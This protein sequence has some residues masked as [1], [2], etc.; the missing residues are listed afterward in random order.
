MTPDAL[1]SVHPAIIEQ[2]LP[3]FCRL[4]R[5]LVADPPTQTLRIRAIRPLDISRKTDLRTIRWLSNHPLELAGVRGLVIENERPNS[6]ALVDQPSTQESCDHP[7]TRYVA[8][9]LERVRR[10]LVTTALSLKRPAGHG[11]RDPSAT[12]AAQVLSSAGLYWMPSIVQ[13]DSPFTMRWR[14]FTGIGTLCE[15]QAVLPMRC[16]LSFLASKK[17]QRFTVS[18]LIWRLTSSAQY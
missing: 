18:R 3:I 8:Y 10:R 2:Q 13:V 12:I 15:C 16:L 9:L 11:V 14:T 4:L 1:A 6:R 17:M 5:Q 7:L